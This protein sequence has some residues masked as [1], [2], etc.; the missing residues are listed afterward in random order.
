MSEDCKEVKEVVQEKAKKSFLLFSGG[1]DSTAVLLK[2]IESCRY[3]EI[4]VA[5]ESAEYMPDGYKNTGYNKALRLFGILKGKADSLKITLNWLDVDLLQPLSADIRG[6]GCDLLLMTHL[7]TIVRH[8]GLNDEAWL[9][10]DRQNI[11]DLHKKYKAFKFSVE[12][13]AM[14]KAGLLSAKLMLLEDAFPDYGTEIARKAGV[15]SYLLEKGLF[16]GCYSYDSESF[17]GKERDDY[18]SGKKWFFNDDE[19]SRETASAIAFAGLF[20]QD[21]MKRIFS[22]KSCED[23]QKEYDK[24]HEKEPQVVEDKKDA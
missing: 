2:L 8:A 7:T 21:G 14:M 3:S 6:N 10:W 4:T 24:R 5:Y 22:A 19:K 16:G 1:Y 12:Y 11:E 17:Q 20:D 15:I 23:I 9:C 18:E 13:M